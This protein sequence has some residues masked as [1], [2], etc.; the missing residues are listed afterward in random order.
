MADLPQSRFAPSPLAVLAVAMSAGITL[1]HYIT[2]RSKAVLI[3]ALVIGISLT[4]FSIA[5]LAKNRATLASGF[6]IGAFLFAG[7]FSRSSTVALRHLI[8]SRECTT[9]ASSPTVSRSS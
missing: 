2:P 5:F 3:V 9:K 1:A 4:F 8:A 6:L 7:W